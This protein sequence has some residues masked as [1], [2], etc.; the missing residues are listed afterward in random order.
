MNSLTKISGIDDV[1]MDNYRKRL[2]VYIDCNSQLDF[3]SLQ[4]NISLLSDWIVWIL[5]PS[6]CFNLVFLEKIIPL[7]V[8]QPL[9]CSTSPLGV[10]SEKDWFVFRL[11]QISNSELLLDQC[12]YILDQYNSSDSYCSVRIALDKDSCKFLK[13]LCTTKSQNE[14]AGELYVSEI[15]PDQT[16]ILTTRK[17]SLV[18]GKLEGVDMVPSLYNFH[19][20]PSGAYEKNNVKIAWPSGQDYIGFTLCALED[21]TICHFVATIEGLYVISLGDFWLRHPDNFSND[22]GEFIQK[23]YGFCYKDGDTIDWYFEQVNKIL[24]K[25]YPLF[26]IQ[27]QQWNQCSKTFNIN[28]RPRRDSEGKFCVS[29]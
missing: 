26:E 23:H 2:E 16:H 20:H 8:N 6:R 11:G 24:Y 18:N 1:K 15:I 19:S 12:I 27:F 7:G 9:I 5:I 29:A 10:K 13:E 22:I 25:G 28:F 3:T 17:A 4:E 21:N 14:I